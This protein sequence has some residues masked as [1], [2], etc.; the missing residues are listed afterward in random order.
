VISESLPSFPIGGS[1]VVP[2]RGIAEGIDPMPRS[3]I[4]KRIVDSLKPRDAEY[5]VWDR[6]LAGFGVR[7]QESGAKSYVVKY[8]AGSGRGAPTRRVTMAKLGT[9]TTSS[10]K[11]VSSPTAPSLFF[12]MVA[13]LGTLGPMEEAVIGE[14]P[15]DQIF[16]L[17]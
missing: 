8:R 9:L 15:R 5:F 10:L 13:V 2:F 4:T 1:S 3:Q 14:R 7:V 11:V 12:T 6:Q 17:R 16:D